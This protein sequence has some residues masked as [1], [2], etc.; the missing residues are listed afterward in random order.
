[1]A[2]PIHQEVYVGA[3]IRG[4]DVE[5][6]QTVGLPDV[7]RHASWIAHGSRSP[8][9]PSWELCA[10]PRAAGKTV[11]K[12]ELQIPSLGLRPWQEVHEVSK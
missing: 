10:A 11:A 7:H 2:V 3:S 1:M 5:G 9:R 6:V 4:P 12:A 8:L